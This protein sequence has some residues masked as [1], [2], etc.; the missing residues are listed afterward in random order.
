MS[1]SAYGQDQAQTTQTPKTL[2]Q[3]AKEMDIKTFVP[4]DSWRWR[5]RICGYHLSIEPKPI[6][7]CRHDEL[8]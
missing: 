7:L 6:Q 2:E 4:V 3:I 8:C 1:I 5:S